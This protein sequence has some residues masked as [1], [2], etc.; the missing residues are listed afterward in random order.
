MLKI[1]YVPIWKFYRFFSAHS[2]KCF[3]EQW[4]CILAINSSIMIQK[5]WNVFNLDCWLKYLPSLPMNLVS[6]FWHRALTWKVTSTSYKA[7][8]ERE[9]TDSKEAYLRWQTAALHWSLNLKATFNQSPSAL[10]TVWLRICRTNL[11]RPA[12][13][14]YAKLVCHKRAWPTL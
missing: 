1:A 2:P 14:K 3:L 5:A 10:R 6:I 8:I 9:I 13:R 7:E 11:R 12:W 4:I